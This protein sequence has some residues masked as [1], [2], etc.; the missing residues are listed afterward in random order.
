MIKRKRPR[1]LPEYVTMFKDRHKKKRYRYRR[2]GYVGGYFKAEPGTEEFRREYA[3]FERGKLDPDRPITSPWLPGSIGDLVTRYVSVPT[4]LGPSLT[5]QSKVRAILDKFRQSYGKAYVADTTFEEIDTI[6]AKRRVRVEGGKRPEGGIEAARKLRKEL[7][8]LFDY[9][10]KIKMIDHNP[11]KQSQEIR[12][13]AGERSKGYHTW[14]EEEIDQ[15]RATHA[16]GTNA[17]LAMELMLWTGQRR[18]DAVHLGPDDIKTGRV[19]LTQTKTGKGL[20]LGLAP[21]LQAALDAME[22]RPGAKCFLINEWGKP[23]TNA[24]FGNKMRQWCDEAGLPQCTAHGLRKAMA[25]RMANMGLSNAAL[26][27]VGGWENDREVSAYIRAANQERL[28]E[29]TIALVAKWESN[30]S[31]LTNGENRA[32]A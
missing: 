12:V 30:R 19:A 2:A 3:E 11:V 32:D 25:T 29:E 16:L 27:S 5:T 23:F 1:F 13:A 20:R 7:V 18:I 26:K 4:R 9:A 28:A 17:R 31:R 15:Y 21:Q 14:S 8:R 6:L 22:P 24:G 10:I